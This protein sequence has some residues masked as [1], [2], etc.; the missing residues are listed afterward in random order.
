MSTAFD[1]QGEVQSVAWG[2]F[3]S[4]VVAI[5]KESYITSIGPG[6]ALLSLVRADGVTILMEGNMFRKVHNEFSV[7]QV[8]ADTLIIEK[9]Q[10]KEVLNM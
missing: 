10:T 2:M 1:D 4:A 8:A 5:Y 3:T 7:I 9:H 6:S